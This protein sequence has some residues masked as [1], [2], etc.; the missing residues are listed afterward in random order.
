MFMLDHSLLPM[1]ALRPWSPK[2]PFCSSADLNPRVVHKRVG[3][4]DQIARRGALS[5][6]ARG[7]VMGPVAGAEPSAPPAPRVGGLLPERH[8]AQ[9]GADPD[10]DQPFRPSRPCAVRLRIGQIGAV[11]RPCL[12]NLLRR[13]VVDEDWL[14]PPTHRDALTPRNRT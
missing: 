11:V 6:A 14:S 8:A 3:R 12:G 5:D 10:H 9:V 1:L 4:Y 7:V 2:H 13:A